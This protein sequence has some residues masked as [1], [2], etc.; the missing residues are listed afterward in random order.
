MKALDTIIARRGLAS[1]LED[2]IWRGIHLLQPMGLCF[3]FA[4]DTDFTSGAVH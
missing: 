2:G 3:G 4:E 1:P